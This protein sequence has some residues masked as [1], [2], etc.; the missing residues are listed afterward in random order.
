MPSA[1]SRTTP[2]QTA[3]MSKTEDRARGPAKDQN[4]PGPTSRPSP[5]PSGT[6]APTRRAA[7][8]RRSEAQAATAPSRAGASQAADSASTP[9]ASRTRGRAS[10]TRST[11]LPICSTPTKGTTEPYPRVAPSSTS[12]TVATGRKSANSR[13]TARA[14]PAGRPGSSQTARAG[15]RNSSAAHA[16]PGRQGGRHGGAQQRGYA[17]LRR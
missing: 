9:G 3:A 16:V 1:D 4:S 5:G 7:R 6:P 14:C 15:E 10:A 17:K 8:E 2:I 11:G 13:I 12:E